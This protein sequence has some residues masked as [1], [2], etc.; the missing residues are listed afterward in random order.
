MNSALQLCLPWPPSVNG[1]LMPMNGKC[2]VDQYGRCHQGRAFMTKTPKARKYWR[3]VADAMTKVLGPM[4]P[5]PIPDRI[6]FEVELR[7]PDRR[8]RDLDNH[9]KVLIDSLT[10]L[11]LW[12]DDSQIDELVVRRG[13]LTKGGA[14]L[15][16][17]TALE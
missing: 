14:A 9:C 12:N 8:P 2:D 11:R 10:Q 16:L 6:R 15:C 1:Y 4:R 3:D 7:A 5:E 13:P 17:I